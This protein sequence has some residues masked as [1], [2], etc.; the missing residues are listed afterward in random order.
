MFKWW[1]TM[2][3]EELTFYLFCVY[4]FPIQLFI[5]YFVFQLF[6]SLL[7]LWVIHYSCN[8]FISVIFCQLFIYFCK[9]LSFAKYFLSFNVEKK[10][11]LTKNKQ[12]KKIFESTMSDQWVWVPKHHLMKL[13]NHAADVKSWYCRNTHKNVSSSCWFACITLFHFFT[14][15][16]MS[17]FLYMACIC[18]SHAFNAA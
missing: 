6:C 8:H 11:V 9:V 1:M 4:F 15:C 12:K 2:N 3:W 13:C 5:Y 10:T 14:G 7:W 18:I 17:E 16:Q